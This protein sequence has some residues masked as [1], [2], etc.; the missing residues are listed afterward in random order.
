MID[1]IL[2]TAENYPLSLPDFASLAWEWIEHDHPE[3]A[4]KVLEALDDNISIF[5]IEEAVLNLIVTPLLTE[6]QKLRFHDI[7]PNSCQVF[8]AMDSST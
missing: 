6:S 8:K 5:E 7:A 4:K 2:S 3:E 1:K